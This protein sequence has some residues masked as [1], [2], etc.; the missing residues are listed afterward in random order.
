MKV[1]ADFAESYAN[2]VKQGDEVNLFFPDLGSNVS[3]TAHYVA[4]FINPMTRTFSIETNIPGD[5]SSY[6]P[7]MVAVMKVVDYKN[8]QAM[9]LPINCILNTGSETYV[10]TVVIENNQKIA[11]RKLIV[12][13]ST[14]DGMAEVISGI[15][16]GES[17]VTTGQF[18][19][20]DGSVVNF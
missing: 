3:T 10:Y 1:K 9:V 14:Y 5:L 15:S 11:R 16:T 6:R 12:L 13:G 18:E 17:I 7:N 20:A 19:I 2:K 8:E 4:K